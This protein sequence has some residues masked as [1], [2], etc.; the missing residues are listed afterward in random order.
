MKPSSPPINWVLLNCGSLTVSANPSPGI[1]SLQ[2]TLTIAGQDSSGFFQLLNNSLI[3]SAPQGTPVQVNWQQPGAAI[4]VNN[5]PVNLSFS[6]IFFSASVV[7]N[8]EVFPISQEYPLSFVIQ[9]NAT[10]STVIVSA[11]NNPN[12]LLYTSAQQGAA[13]L[14]SICANNQPT[15]VGGGQWVVDYTL[16]FQGSDGNV[17]QWD[18]PDDI[19]HMPGEKGGGGMSFKRSPA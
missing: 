5:K 12:C 2:G 13:I 9:P 14:A 1:Y 11:L 19:E 10:N 16:V 3:I 8:G 17:Y 15:P 4:S 18:P 6:G 7:V